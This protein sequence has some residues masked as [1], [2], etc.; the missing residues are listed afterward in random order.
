MSSKRPL[1]LLAAVCLAPFIASFALYFFWT[2]EGGQVNYGTLLTPR[3]LPA[4]LLRTQSGETIRLDSL[5]GKWILLT[6]DP[7]G[8]DESCAKK[9]YATRQ[10]RTMTGKERERVQR[11]WL[12]TTDGAPPAELAAAHPDLLVAA[13]PPAL[14]AALPAS[15]ATAI[16]LIDPLGNLILQYPTD[17]DIKK[18]NK[19]LGRLLYASRIG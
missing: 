18:L 16:F 8:C 13:A 3:P 14:L 12:T 4:A 6:L 2:P 17:P 1:Y 7:P 15:A 10:A 11:L 5:R 19:D 9:L